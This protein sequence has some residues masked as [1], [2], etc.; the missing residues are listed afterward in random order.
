MIC[1]LPDNVYTS[2]AQQLQVAEAKVQ[3]ITPS[4]TEINVYSH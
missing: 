4:Y 2:V 3:E 1:A